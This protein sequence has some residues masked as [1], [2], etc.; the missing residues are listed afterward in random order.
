MDTEQKT[1]TTEKTFQ[2]AHDILQMSE[3]EFVKLLEASVRIQDITNRVNLLIINAATE[4]ICTGE[5]KFAI[6]VNEVRK[7][8][9][10]SGNQSRIISETLEKLSGGFDF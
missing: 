9:K 7:L 10:E 8:V 2:P 4:A 3:R 5:D 6:V 1:V